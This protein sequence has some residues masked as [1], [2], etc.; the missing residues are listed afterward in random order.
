MQERSA[1]TPNTPFVVHYEKMR[2]HLH[3]TATNS[4]K[5]DSIARKIQTLAHK[6]DSNTIF[7]F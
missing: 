7:A 3:E 1:I 6:S 2:N 5:T 4:A